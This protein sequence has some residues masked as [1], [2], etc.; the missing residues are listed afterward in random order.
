MPSGG[1]PPTEALNL[2]NGPKAVVPICWDLN[3]DGPPVSSLLVYYALVM[4]NKLSG[5]INIP[6]LSSQTFK[7]Y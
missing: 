6:G 1:E 2:G 4:V 7:L 3:G 5:I